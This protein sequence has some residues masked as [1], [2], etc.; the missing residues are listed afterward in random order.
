MAEE[1]TTNG[2]QDFTKAE[3]IEE[4]DRLQMEN[5]HMRLQNLRLQ[6]Q[7]AQQQVQELANA[8]QEATFAAIEFRKSLDK[9]YG[10]PITPAAIDKTGR[11]LRKAADATTALPIPPPIPSEN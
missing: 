11:L 4:V 3:F 5:H 1:T 6:Q 7:L 10:F 8:T 2:E 9:K